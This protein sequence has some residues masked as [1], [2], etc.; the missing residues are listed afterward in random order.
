MTLHADARTMIVRLS[1]LLLSCLLMVNVASAAKIA[2]G[3]AELAGEADRIVV[4]DVI[5]ADSRWTHDGGSIE[6]AIEV[7][8]EA[9]LKGAGADVERIIIPGGTV[10]DISMLTTSDPRFEIGDHVILFLSADDRLIADAQGAWLCDDA[11]A[12][13]MSGGRNRMD[14]LTLQPVGVLVDDIKRVLPADERGGALPAYDGPFRVSAAQRYATLGY[15]WS[16]QDNPMG[17]TYELNGNCADASAGPPQNQ[18]AALFLGAAAW[19]DAGSD[20]SFSLGGPTASTDAAFDG[21][22]VVFFCPAGD[23]GMAAQTIAQTRIW[24]S[25][26]RILEW[27]IVFNDAQYE[28]WD[29]LT[30]S[31][32]S[33]MDIQAVMTHEMGHALGLDHSAVAG[34]TMFPT[35]GTCNLDTRTLHQDDID[36]LDDLYGQ[37]IDISTIDLLGGA[38]GDSYGY[39]MANVGDV[40][41]DGLDDLAIG[42]PWNDDAGDDAGR[43][44]VVSAVSGAVIWSQFGQNPGDLLGFSVAKAGLIDGDNVPDVI[45]GAPYNDDRDTN[46]GRVYLFSGADG[47]QIKAIRGQARGDLFGYSVAGGGDLDGDGS[48]DYI[49]GAPKNDDHRS[50]AGRVQLYSGSTGRSIGAVFGEDA[51]DHFGFSVAIVGRADGDNADDFLVG[52]PYHNRGG[53]NR[54]KTYL[55]SGD[56]QSIIHT[57]RG[58]NAGD[59][60]GR[61]VSGVGDLDGDGRADYAVGSPFFDKSGAPDTGRL[62]VFDGR[63]GDFLWGLNGQRADD[64]MG[65]AVG[66]AGDVNRDGVPD[67]LVGAL[68]ATHSV[69]QGGRAYIRSGTNGS[70]ILSLDGADPLDRLGAAVVGIGDQNGNG[71]SDVAFA[72]T[73]DDAADL[74]AGRV[75]LID[76]VVESR[77]A[78]YGSDPNGY[79]RLLLPELFEDG[80][81]PAGGIGL[82]E[83]AIQ[84]LDDGVSIRR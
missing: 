23:C 8:V 12:V 53:T 42:S 17:E 26:S 22:N 75:F 47:S 25:G 55:Y 6:T 32:S 66:A 73:Y 77:S 84:E 37:L 3:T 70:G 62:E 4:G 5:S 9:R 21:E 58:R 24:F 80:E 52:S 78:P 33:M 81:G 45:V 83:Q 13:Q 41:G 68:F 10:G 60:F 20:F 67:V 36:G 69:E 65:F 54:G 16:Y 29:G 59:Q 46:A 72:A 44:D 7:R 56:N 74:N 82:I 28:F 11:L 18:I 27:D 15:D 35:T 31:C 51:G 43:I 19:N 63:N 1:V 48:D 71:S 30:G 39:A 34:A 50:D 2:A 64:R 14:E 61:A 57:R 38:R 76:A 79:M 40:D 49:V